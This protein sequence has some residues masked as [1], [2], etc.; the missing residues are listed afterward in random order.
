MT[1]SEKF[2]NR[3]LQRALMIARLSA[4]Q[5]S[6]C[7]Y[8]TIGSKPDSPTGRNALRLGFQVAYTKSILIRPGPGL[9]ASP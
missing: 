6:N 8:A 5:Q 9:L 4:A 7:K 1:T 3:G 2:R